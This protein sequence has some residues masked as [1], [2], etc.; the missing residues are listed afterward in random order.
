MDQFIYR[1]FSFI[2][3]LFRSFWSYIEYKPFNNDNKRTPN[4]EN[5]TRKRSISFGD[6]Y[7]FEE[8]YDRVPEGKFISFDSLPAD[9][10]VSVNKYNELVKRRSR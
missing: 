3:Y 5:K 2:N 1:L 7:R 6:N 10:S 9:I 8:L 4:L